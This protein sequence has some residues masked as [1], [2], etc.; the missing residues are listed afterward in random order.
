MVNLSTLLLLVPLHSLDHPTGS[1]DMSASMTPTTPT[2][3]STTVLPPTISARLDSFLNRCGDWHLLDDLSSLPGRIWVTYAMQHGMHQADHWVSMVEQEI[4][5]GLELLGLVEG[6]LDNEEIDELDG[7]CCRELWREIQRATAS[8]HWVLATLQVR[9][10]QVRSGRALVHPH[11]FR[12]LGPASQ[13]H[14][15]GSAVTLP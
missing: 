15:M 4:G 7:K 5:T 10:D 11:S 14:A 6:L 12:P 2:S 1:P 3:P 8:I 9:L 13:F